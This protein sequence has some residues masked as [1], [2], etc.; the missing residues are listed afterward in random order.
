MSDAWLTALLAALT[1]VGGAIV[2][3][4]RWAVNRVT[5]AMDDNTRAMLENT[6]A[7]TR[8]EVKIDQVSDWVEEHTPVGRPPPKKPRAR[9]NPQGTPIGGGTY[10]V[11]RPKGG[12]EER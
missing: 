1:G 2:A 10:S 12:G 6:K 11:T 4:L 5:K 3:A 9:T 8:L 7:S